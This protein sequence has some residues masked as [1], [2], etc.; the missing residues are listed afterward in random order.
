[1]DYGYF[2]DEGINKLQAKDFKGALSDFN[3]A[4]E[5]C[6]EKD[7]FFSSSLL[8]MRGECYQKLGRS[9]KA[10]KDYS[11]AIQ[12]NPRGVASAYINRGNLLLESNDSAGIEDLKKSDEITARSYWIAA[13]YLY[14]SENFEKGIYFSDKAI[15]KAPHLLGGY[16][17]RAQCK[18]KLLDYTGAINDLNKALEIDP[19]DKE[20]TAL[21]E[22]CIQIK[23][24]MT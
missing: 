9:E 20:I 15:K 24:I 1:M 22:S 11:K 23:Q 5:E 2:R 3:K 18:F 12:I 14:E 19:K 21:I 7:W 10:I 8:S 17:W 13:K 4:I 6:P 16:W